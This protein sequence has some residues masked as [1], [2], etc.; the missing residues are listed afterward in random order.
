MLQG[1]LP[2]TMWA[3]RTCASILQLLWKVNKIAHLKNDLFLVAAVV[4]VKMCD[5]IFS[6]NAWFW[7]PENVLKFH[8][9]PVLKKL[10]LLCLCLGIRMPHAKF[11]ADPHQLTIRQHVACC[12]AFQ[13]RMAWVDANMVWM[14]WDEVCL[15]GI[16][17]FCCFVWL[18]VATYLLTLLIV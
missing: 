8:N 4:F 1:G 12:L 18:S 7:C 9:F 3:C 11:C 6:L 10:N 17:L 15:V 5:S 16:T 14:R 2:L 13:N